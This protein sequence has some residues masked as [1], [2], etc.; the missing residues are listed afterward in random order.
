ML[1]VSDADDAEP[2]GS[3]DATDEKEFDVAVELDKV[4]FGM[5]LGSALPRWGLF[6]RAFLAAS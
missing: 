4:G 5:L 2:L 3:L 1:V 6:F